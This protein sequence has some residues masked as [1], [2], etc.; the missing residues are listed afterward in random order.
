MPFSI[1]TEDVLPV[2]MRLGAESMPLATAFDCVNV[3]TGDFFLTDTSVALGGPTPL[4]YSR[5]Y[6]S[7]LYY[8]SRRGYGNGINFPLRL[9]HMYS[10]ARDKNEVLLVAEEREAAVIQYRGRIHGQ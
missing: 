10:L 2:D 1:C 9:G 3:I 4:H 5:F 7:G 6:D 8:P